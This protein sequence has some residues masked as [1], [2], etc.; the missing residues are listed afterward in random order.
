MECSHFAK[1]DELQAQSYV[2]QKCEI[3]LLPSYASHCLKQVCCLA[4]AVIIFCLTIVACYV[5]LS[6]L[7]GSYVCLGPV[8]FCTYEEC[9]PFLNLSPQGH[10]QFN[11]LA[12]RCCV[13]VT[14]GHSTHAKAFTLLKSY[15]STHP[16][17]HPAA[18]IQ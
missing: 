11:I 7:N 1:G 4:L 6:C 17:I 9:K 8:F 5:G 16:G 14:H 12:T 15:H 10:S 13:H 18:I 3:N 2:F